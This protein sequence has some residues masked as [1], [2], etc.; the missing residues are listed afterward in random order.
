MKYIH[1]LFYMCAFYIPAMLSAQQ[2][3]SGS[4]TSLNS[5]KNYRLTVVPIIDTTSVEGLSPNKCQ[6][7]VE[8]F[9]GTGRLIQTVQINVAPDFSDLVVYQEYDFV[10]RPSRKWLPAVFTN[11]NGA[12]ISYSALETAA[13]NTYA[14]D[15]KPYSTLTYEASP[16]ERVLK[17]ANPGQDWYANDR[18]VKTSYLTNVSGNDTLNCIHYHMYSNASDTLVTVSRTGNYSTGSLRVIHSSDEDGH[19][20]WEFKDGHNRTVLLRQLLSGSSFYDTYYIY[21]VFGNLGA[22]LPPLASDR[23]RTDNNWDNSISAD[24]RDYSFLYQYDNRNRCRSKRL[25]GCGWTY[26]I[27]DK[28]DR[29]IFSQDEE[30]RKRN[31]WSF[32]LPD[33]FNR[34][35]LTG[36]CRN[37]FN[38]PAAVSPLDTTLVTVTRN[39]TTSVYKGY[40]SPQVTLVTPVVLNVNYYD[41]Y[42]FMGKNGVPSSTDFNYESGTGFGERYPDGARTCLTGTMSAKLDGSSTASYLYS[43]MYYDEKGRIVQSK[44]TSQLSG[45]I[46][47]EYFSYNFTGQ[48]VKHKHIH[49]A[50]GKSTQTELNTYTYDHAGRLLTHT[51]QLNNGSNVVLADNEYDKLG[52]L[53]SNKRNGQLNLKTDYTYNVRSWT[54]SMSGPLFSQTLYYND[55]R[56][57]NSNTPCYNGN[58]S[59]MDWNAANNVTRGYDFAYNDLSRLIRA[60]YLE[61]NVRSNKFS[62]TYSYDKHGNINSLSRRGNVGTTT[63]GVIDNLTLSYQGNQLL[64]VEDAAT[65]PSLSMSMDFKDGAHQN[66]EYTYDK[67]GNLTKDLNKGIAS[68]EYNLLN[69]AKRITFSGVNSPVHEYVYS[70]DGEKL[71]VIHQSSTQKRTDYVGNMIY[72]NGSLKR[73]LVDGGYIENGVYYFYLEDHLG[74]NRVVAKAD[75]TVIQTNH[76]YPYGMLF[77]EST[78]ADKQPYKY[79]GKELDRENGLDWY[80]YGARQME[81]DKGRFIAIDPM[82]EKFYNWSPY[83]Y[84]FGNPIKYIDPNGALTSPYYTADGI[85]LGVDEE[86]FTGD[87]YIT[88]EETFKKHA[89]KGVVNSRQMQKESNTI[90]MKDKDLSMEAESHIYTDVLKKSED[91]ELNMS[92]LYNGEISI[93]EDVVRK[94]IYDI[95]GK[96]Y[97]NPEGHKYDP[98]F[99]QSYVD[100]EIRVTVRKGSNKLSL[101]SVETIQNRIGVHEYYGHGIMNWS[102][103][104]THW[105]CYDAQIKHSTFKL[106][107]KDQQNE[108]IQRR[109]LFYRTRNQQ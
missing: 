53:L 102:T 35:C 64:K 104:K 94:G 105:K 71:S 51:Y 103:R 12:S 80:D 13:S 10:G 7:T 76:Y 74:N 26:Y 48:P 61:N 1:L 28:A 30:Q 70:S 59:A 69:L 3:S 98:Q 49:S 29:L 73:I 20:S 78:Y 52:R 46:E 66:I 62:T 24:L 54:K 86:G 63:Y 18:N 15:S 100:G 19:H 8:Y 39:N 67:N 55:H 25:P 50:T 43:I 77:A 60:D 92:R 6:R 81:V 2:T 106:L 107:P 91:T 90:A 38:V 85:F 108:I 68:I 101:Y 16:L 17:Q 72:E 5:Y 75:G 47:K 11:N 40:S 84:C 23:M 83:N 32:S 45:G 82:M 96:G 31:E 99:S 33:V 57:N 95:I 4:G 42:E 56:S 88:D 97:N 87:I 109:D 37:T 93:V 79:N 41:D 27:Y 9:D 44:S 14:G 34:V 22:V 89:K 58:I 21:D 36:T 65:S